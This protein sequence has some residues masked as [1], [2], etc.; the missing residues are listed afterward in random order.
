MFTIEN[1][2][3]PI[4]EVFLIDSEM[5]YKVK[6]VDKT[7]VINFMGALYKARNKFD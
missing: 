5:H 2:G 6:K 4:T 7:W 3:S 1:I